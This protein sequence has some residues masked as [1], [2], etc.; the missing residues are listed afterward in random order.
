MKDIIF[1]E[2]RDAVESAVLEIFAEIQDKYESLS[3]EVFSIREKLQ[4]S[5]LSV[6]EHNFYQTRYNSVFSK[7]VV[8]SKIIESLGNC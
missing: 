7:Y 1:T 5:T 3:E 6:S 2:N 4:D 8:Y